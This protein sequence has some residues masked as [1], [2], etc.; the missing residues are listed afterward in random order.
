MTEKKTITGL[1]THM[2]QAMVEATLAGHDIGSWQIVGSGAHHFQAVCRQCN[3][4]A[5][6][7]AAAAI[8]IPG[9][10]PR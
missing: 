3:Q 6:A 9:P 4:A 1:K 2:M 8:I 7:S 5:L 10:C